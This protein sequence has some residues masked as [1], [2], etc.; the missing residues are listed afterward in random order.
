MGTILLITALAIVTWLFCHILL[1]IDRRIR[2]WVDYDVIH[3]EAT[4]QIEGS[5]IIWAMR[6]KEDRPE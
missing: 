5:D 1:E 4:G 6:K 2:R 3:R